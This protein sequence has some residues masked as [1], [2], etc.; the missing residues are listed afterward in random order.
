MIDRVSYGSNQAADFASYMAG[1][2]ASTDT[3]VTPAPES[4][5]RL[6]HIEITATLDSGGMGCVYRARD[7]ILHASLR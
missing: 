5:H 4:G 1:E 3:V 7:L 6:A 2:Q